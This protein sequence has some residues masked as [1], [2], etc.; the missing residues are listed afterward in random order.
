MIPHRA[1]RA[2][3]CEIFNNG[4]SSLLQKKKFSEIGLKNGIFREGRE[5][6][7]RL[8]CWIRCLLRPAIT[9]WGD[10]DRP[11]SCHQVSPLTY[12]HLKLEDR[13]APIENPGFRFHLTE[14]GI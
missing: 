12:N 2:I 11:F 10:M 8:E 5:R 14:N 1:P 6:Q 9:I 4:I 7:A 3:A 13:K